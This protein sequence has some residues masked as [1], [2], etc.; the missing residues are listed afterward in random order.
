HPAEPG[1]NVA[2][3]VEAARDCHGQG[4]VLAVFPELGLSGYAIEDLFLQ[5]A[6]LDAVEAATAALVAAS[7]AIRPLLVVGAPLRWRSR[8]YN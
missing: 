8:I 6:L 4:A 3:I 1:R 7:A 2:E 5:D